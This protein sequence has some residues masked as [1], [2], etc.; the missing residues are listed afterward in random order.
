MSD[1]SEDN[2]SSN[3][4]SVE[5]ENCLKLVLNEWQPKNGFNKQ[6]LTQKSDNFCDNN[7]DNSEG[8]LLKSYLTSVQPNESLCKTSDNPEVVTIDSDDEEPNISTATM[9]SLVSKNVNPSK[10]SQSLPQPKLSLSLG[11]DDK[12]STTNGVKGFQR[13]F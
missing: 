7:S 12:K 9:E 1:L 5:T 10:Y 11:S 2:I 13:K 6:T 4:K 8:T 3:Q